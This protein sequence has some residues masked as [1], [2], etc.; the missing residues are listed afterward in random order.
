MA[1]PTE[2]FMSSLF[3]PFFSRS[4][5]CSNFEFWEGDARRLHFYPERELWGS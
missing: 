2:F 3:E 1:V 5:G 4:T